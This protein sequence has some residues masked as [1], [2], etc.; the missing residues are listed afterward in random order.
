M[1][2]THQRSWR[3]A[4]AWLGGVVVLA[5]LAWNSVDGIKARF[6]EGWAELRSYQSSGVVDTSWGMRV[7]MATLTM[8]MV[9]D[10][11]LL[12]HGIG[13]WLGLWQARAQGGGRLLE[14]QLTPHNE[15]LLVA[16]QVGA[17][18]LFLLLV[19]LAAVWRLAWNSGPTGTAA[20][21]AWTLLATSSLFNA[22]LR[23]AKFSLPLLTLAALA[24]IAGRSGSPPAR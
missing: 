23:D 1:A 18:G 21:L 16:S 6:V 10:R 15:Y 14:E 7:R 3:R 24:G 17:V 12:G 20:L 5:V 9:R 2:A 13:S 4:I 19:G 11:P 22:M 8:E